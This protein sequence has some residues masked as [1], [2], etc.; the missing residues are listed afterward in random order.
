MFLKNLPNLLSLIRLFLVI[1]FVYFFY[2]KQYPY[3]FY[4]FM[5]AAFTDALDG[6]LARV[7]NCQ[8]NLGL[9]IDPLAD[10]ILIVSCFILLGLQSI[11][12]IWIVALVL[13]R[14]LAIT[15]GA[16]ISLYICNKQHA[17]HPSLLSKLN[18]VLQMLLIVCS[19]LHITYY[20]IETIY[21]N[22]LIYLVAAT[23]FLSFFHYFWI[24]YHHFM[25]KNKNV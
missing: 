10:K 9:I 14:D 8:S 17:L 24:W 21:L 15:F 25:I 4:I 7:L 11:L 12:P 20:P 16:F 2:N 6:W 1:P 18:T 13:L 19:L 22:Y 23:T 5:I 3:S